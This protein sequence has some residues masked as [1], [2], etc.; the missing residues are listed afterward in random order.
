MSLFQLFIPYD[1]V[2]LGVNQSYLPNS[3]IVQRG[4]PVQPSASSFYSG[5]AGAQAGFY[6]T[7]GSTLTQQ[8]PG[9]PQLHQATGYSLQGYNSQSSATA[10]GLQSFGSQVR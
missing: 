3:Q 2:Q 1:T 8:A 9:A 10:V 5:S 7:P 4:A 6:Q